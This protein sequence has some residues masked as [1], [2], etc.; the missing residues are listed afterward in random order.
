MAHHSPVK[1]VQSSD[2]MSESDAQEDKFGKL[3][4]Y[5]EE[6]APVFEDLTAEQKERRLLDYIRNLNIVRELNKTHDNLE[7]AASER[8]ESDVLLEKLN[9]LLPDLEF[10]NVYILVYSDL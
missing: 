5:P 1:S 10:P 3:L 7:V 4:K 6:I 9:R 2:A 8:H